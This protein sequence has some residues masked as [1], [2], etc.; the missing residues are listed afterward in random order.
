MQRI[1][2]E[3]TNEQMTAHNVTVAQTDGRAINMHET[4]PYVCPKTCLTIRTADDQTPM[5]MPVCCPSLVFAG[6][7]QRPLGFIHR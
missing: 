6:L 7:R 5:F 1:T 3:Q 4:S 2:D